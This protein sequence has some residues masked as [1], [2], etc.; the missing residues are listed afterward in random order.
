MLPTLGPLELMIMLGIVLIVFG[1]GKIAGVGKSLSGNRSSVS[2][3]PRRFG[4][5]PWQAPPESSP[6]E[7]TTK[8][9]MEPMANSLERYRYRRL[10]PT[11]SRG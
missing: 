1:G 11:A 4:S 6:A 7:P 3:A 9:P 8:P 2:T 10:S 5:H